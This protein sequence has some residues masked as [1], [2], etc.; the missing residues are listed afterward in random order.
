M[1]DKSQVGWIQRLKLLVRWLLAY[2]GLIVN[3][4]RTPAH[5]VVVVGY[6]GHLDVLL[7]WPFAKLRGV[8]IVWDAFLSLYN[9]VVEDRQMVGPRHPLAWL[10]Y[11]WEWLACRA[12]DTVI[13]DTKAHGDYFVE[14]YKLDKHQQ[15]PL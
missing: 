5:D 12:A 8:P 3:Y 14:R 15:F 11:G 4:C 6:L 13:L 9:T 2:P 7:L 1:A 10:L